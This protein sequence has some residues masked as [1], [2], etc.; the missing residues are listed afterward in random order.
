MLRKHMP[1]RIGLFVSICV[2]VFVE[3]RTLHSGRH[4]IGQSLPSYSTVNVD[5]L[6]A[7]ISKGRLVVL[8]A[9]TF[10]Y[11]LMLMNFVC[12]LRSLGIDNLLVGAFDEDLY[13]FAHEHDVAVYKAMP[14][15]QGLD[16]NMKCEFGTG[17]FHRVTKMK[18]R[19]VLHILKRGYDVL[20]TDTDVVWLNNPIPDMLNNGG[21][22]ILVVQDDAPSPWRVNSGFYLAR[23]DPVTKQALQNIITHASSS[24]TS[25]QPSFFVI[26]CGD[27]GRHAVGRM[28]CIDP[29]TGLETRFL[30]MDTYPNGAHESLWNT[31]LPIV[32]HNN[33]LV[34]LPK[35][36]QRL[37]RHGLWFLADEEGASIIRCI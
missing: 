33:W 14:Q 28:R 26:L 4:E 13:R 1:W 18:S 24:K 3:Y 8:T 5:T 25:E 17:C 31:S 12:N 22:G 30:P 27:R 6:L 36:F 2:L 37:E 34:G 11:R 35:K 16:T 32:L 7:R 21:P 20:W 29:I 15:E 10:N 23:A 9:T 19:A